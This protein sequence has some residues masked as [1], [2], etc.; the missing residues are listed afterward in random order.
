VASPSPQGWFQKLMSHRNWTRGFQAIS[1]LSFTMAIY[2]YYQQQDFI[3]CI[4]AYNDTQARSGAARSQA[5]E[6]SLAAVD[7]SIHAAA[8]ATNRQQVMTALAEY[9]KAREVARE[10]RANNP[11]PPPPSER[12]G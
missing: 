10:R 6:D 1:V 2:V 4:A 7:A 5:I 3:E 9:E 8:T 11:P 12:C